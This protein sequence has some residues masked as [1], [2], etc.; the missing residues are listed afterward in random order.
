[1]TT[2][3]P[4][5]CFSS[6]APSAASPHFPTNLAL[7]NKRNELTFFFDCLQGTNSNFSWGFCLQSS[8]NPNK[9]THGLSL[10]LW[11]GSTTSRKPVFWRWCSVCAEWFLICPPAVSAFSLFGFGIKNSPFLNPR[12]TVLFKK[13]DFFL[14]SLLLLSCHPLS[15]QCICAPGWAGLFCNE[16]CPAGYFGESCREPCICMNGADCDGVSG[17]CTCAPGFMVSWK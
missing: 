6:T 17:T 5:S 2:G 10:Y 9:Y 15:G 4:Q 16:T 12:S 11:S 3:W 1:M 7:E 8:T 14:S 13:T